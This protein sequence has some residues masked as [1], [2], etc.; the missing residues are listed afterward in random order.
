MG[1]QTR[2]LALCRSQ[3]SGWSM[4]AAHYRGSTPQDLM[5]ALS[6]PA[7]TRCPK[8][9]PHVLEGLQSAMPGTLPW[10]TT[11]AERMPAPSFLAAT[12]FSRPGSHAGHFTFCCVVRLHSAFFQGRFGVL[13]LQSSF[14]MGVCVS[15]CGGFHPSPLLPIAHFN[16]ARLF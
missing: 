9:T 4:T 14:S 3:R 16:D 10:F 8:S 2:V 6:Q 1:R 7:S 15:K 11:C 5:S 13:S 12:F